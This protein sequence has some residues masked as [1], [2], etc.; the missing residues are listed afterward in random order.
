V[1]TAEEWHS[2]IAAHSALPPEAAT[3][4]RERGFTVV[5]GPLLDGGT[6]R[7]AEAYEH[8]ARTADP[9]DVSVRSST[10]INDFVNRDPEFDGI[11][12]F[13]PLL[14]AC[15]S[16]IG[17]PFKLSGMRARTVEP[18]AEMEAL[19]VDVK[20][21]ARDWPI[22]GGIFM[23]DEF[24]P[25]NGATRFVPGSHLQAASPEACM[26]NPKD[27][28][29]RQVLACGAAGSLIIFHASAWHG[30]TANQSQ[31]PRRSIQAHFVARDAQEST[32]H[33]PRM[34]AETLQ[35]IG[36]LARYILD[37]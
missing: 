4:L 29:D 19:H 35:R 16:I 31:L 1:R 36:D 5:A 10:R 34:R 27:R 18:G 2:I 7:Y 3:Q 32:H 20:H 37:V 23:I 15:T 26:A 30:H 28:H 33:G 17:R 25:G 12:I 13:G 21:G 11:Y 6:D 24:T 22:V 8:A 9:S 14:A